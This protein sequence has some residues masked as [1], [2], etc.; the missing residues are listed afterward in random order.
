M[1]KHTAI[2]AHLAL[3]DPRL[4]SVLSYLEEVKV[5]P[6]KTP[7]VD[8]IETIINQQLSDKAGMIIFRR[9]RSAFP[10]GK[11]TPGAILRRSDEAIRALGVSWSKVTYL[12]SL[13]SAVEKKHVRLDTLKTKTDDEV[14]TELTKVK[15][16]GRW[17]AEMFLMF[18]LGREDIFSYGDLG[19]RRGLQ[20]LYG[21]KKEPSVK[22][23]EKI[24]IKWKPYRTYGARLLW[25]YLDLT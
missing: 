17:T 18:S 11:I 19:L 21:F 15:G 14:I 10:R 13:A 7:F 20:K 1:V 23:M 6:S 16:I 3:V 8:L 9:F 4:S 25:K 2:R 22:Q 5:V 12:K 24:V